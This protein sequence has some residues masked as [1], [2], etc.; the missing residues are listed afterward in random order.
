M[1]YCVSD[2]DAEVVRVETSKLASCRD[3]N[4]TNHHIGGMRHACGLRKYFLSN[5]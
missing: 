2:S 4:A 3:P 5:K 1:F